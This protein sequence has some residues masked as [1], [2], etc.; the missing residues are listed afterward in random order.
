MA[1]FILLALAVLFLILGYGMVA[2]V[3]TG[4]ALALA[5]VSR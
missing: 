1:S 5:F 4:V 2:L 3:L